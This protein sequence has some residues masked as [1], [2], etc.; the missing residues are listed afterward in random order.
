M[1]S[2]LTTTKSGEYR[3]RSAGSKPSSVR[4]PIPPTTS[5]TNK[6]VTSSLMS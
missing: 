6:M 1:F 4:F 2:P 5:P 3:S